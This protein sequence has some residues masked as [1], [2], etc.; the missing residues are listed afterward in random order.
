M[1]QSLSLHVTAV[2]SLLL[3]AAAAS[4]TMPLPPGWGPFGESGLVHG[5][6]GAKCPLELASFKRT[7]IDSR[8]APDLGICSY[9]GDNG[10]EGL[11]RVRQYVRG[12][13]DTPL[14]IQND[15]ALIEPKPGTPDV[16]IGFRVG[17]GPEKNGVPTRQAV[18][19]TANNGLL[20]DCIG[21]Q[22]ASDSSEVGFDFAREC[23]GLQPQKK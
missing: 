3:A 21:R 10:R 6:S 15:E 23:I 1:Q 9:S 20:I 19:T 16:V 5:E 18:L 17:P 13:G 12:Q 11:V 7:G 14:A 8:G 4:H 22:I 2:A